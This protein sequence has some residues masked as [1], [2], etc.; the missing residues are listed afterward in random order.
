[1]K[2]IP[3][4]LALLAALTLTLALS[5]TIWQDRESES[6][7]APVS[8]SAL[9]FHTVDRA[10]NAADESL[11]AGHSLIILN[12]WE[13]WCGPCVREM[14]D[15]EKLYE[16]YKDRGLLI[17]GIYS[18][19]EMED[20]VD[21]VLADAGTSYPILRYCEDFDVFASGYVPTTVFLDEKGE[22]L[23]EL[24]VGSRSFSGW[25]ELVLSVLK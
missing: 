18:A 2:K 10:G 12:F 16:T 9:R 6:G 11:F 13:P 22:I 3:V 14:P 15:L 23:S 7:E 5:I 8:A 21:K 24:L 25:E 17:L 19:E 4:L 20:R 1:M